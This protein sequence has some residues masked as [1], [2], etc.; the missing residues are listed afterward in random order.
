MNVI[1]LK[2]YAKQNNITYEAVRQ[3]V[4]RY[5]DELQ[6]HI[7][8][9]GRQQFLDEEAVAFLD[10]RRQKN[11]VVIIQQDKDELI[12]ALKADKER[13]LIKIAEQADKISALNERWADKAEVIAKADQLQLEAANAR[14]ELV[15][16]IAEAQKTV[17]EL[18]EVKTRVFTL[19]NE[20]GG[21]KDKL[22]QSEDALKDAWTAQEA[23]ERAKEEAERKIRA[24]EERSFG[25][26]LKDLFKKKGK[27]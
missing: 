21:L 23:A 1:S 27:E 11:P 8:K 18:S 12:E 20:N 13:L 9:D 7:I 5:K 26:K 6:E 22:G 14:K 19:E 2:D 3:Q 25:E 17:S 10:A 16:K 15:E 24:L 4:A